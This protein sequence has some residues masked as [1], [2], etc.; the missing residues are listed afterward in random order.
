LKQQDETTG[1]QLILLIQIPK[2]Y[3]PIP[4]PIPNWSEL[5]IKTKPRRTS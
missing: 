5:G 3:E 1:K 2:F 4:I